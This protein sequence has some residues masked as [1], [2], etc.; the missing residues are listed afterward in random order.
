VAQS[1]CPKSS[2]FLKLA[3]HRLAGHGYRQFNGLHREKD[4]LVTNQF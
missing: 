1:G 2:N 3:I 4:E